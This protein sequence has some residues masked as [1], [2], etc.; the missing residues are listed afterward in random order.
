MFSFLSMA[1]N[2]EERKV[3]Y[4]QTPYGFISTVAVSDGTHPYETAVQDDRYVND[5]DPSD[6]GMTIVE[7]YDSREEAEQGHARW[8]ALMLDSVPP[9]TL[10]DCQNSFISQMLPASTLTWSLRVSN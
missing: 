8:R 7:G 4:E 9:A 1:D 5:S 3:G 6:T 2:Y 10:A